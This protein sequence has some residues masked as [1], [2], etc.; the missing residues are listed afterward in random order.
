MKK[1][2]LAVVL[3]LCSLSA[4]ANKPD[5]G[6]LFSYV[7][8]RGLAFFGTGFFDRKQIKRCGFDRKNAKNL[9]FVAICGIKCPLSIENGEKIWYNKRV[10]LK[11]EE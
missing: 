1:N 4:Y 10:I 2:L 9:V 11:T 8:G 7:N 6:Y 3:V 5:Y